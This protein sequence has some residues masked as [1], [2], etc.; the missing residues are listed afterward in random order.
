[1]ADLDFRIEAGSLQMVVVQRQQVSAPS[2]FT[3][4][5]HAVRLFAQ[6]KFSDG[7][8]VDLQQLAQLELLTLSAKGSVHNFWVINSYLIEI[9]HVG[10]REFKS[11]AVGHA[12]NAESLL[13]AHALSVNLMAANVLIHKHHA[14]MGRA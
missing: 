13:S 14:L 7:L 4:P 3:R 5:Q 10:R 2:G 6:L 12:Q 11:I 9:S 8:V 1:M